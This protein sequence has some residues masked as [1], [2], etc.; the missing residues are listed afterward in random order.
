MIAENS[1]QKTQAK[2]FSLFAFFGNVGIFLGVLIGGFAKP[3]EQYPK[4]FGSVKFFQDF[5]YAL[6]TIVSGIFIAI[7]LVV[8][9]FFVEEV[10]FCKEQN[11]AN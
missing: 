3:A 7:A 5:P 2:A 6:P 1:T 9:I 11:S 10:S 8:T 4:L